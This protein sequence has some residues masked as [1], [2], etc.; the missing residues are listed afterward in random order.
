MTGA[1]PAATS[2]LG[3]DGVTVIGLLL[4]NIAA[5]FWVLKTRF[6][7][8]GWVY[9]AKCKEYDELKSLLF[10]QATVTKSSME[11]AKAAVVMVE[12]HS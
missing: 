3:T 6:M 5:I 11:T 12:R 4:A 9:E 10:A 7:V 2:L 8:P 1:E